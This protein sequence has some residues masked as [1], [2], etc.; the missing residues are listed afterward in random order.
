MKKWLVS[1]NIQI[2]YIIRI[3]TVL[4]CVDWE[5]VQFLQYGSARPCARL[6]K[7]FKSYPYSLVADSQ[8]PI[9]Y[10]YIYGDRTRRDP[11]IRTS[12]Q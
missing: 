10:I 6:L 1:P 4:N 5:H 11:L 2:I 3:C 9:I 12:H 8:Q 7:A